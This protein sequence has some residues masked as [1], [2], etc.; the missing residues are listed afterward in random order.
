M[1]E[2]TLVNR[3]KIANGVNGCE[4]IVGRSDQAFYYDIRGGHLRQFKGPY[5][6]RG[7]NSK[8]R[9]KIPEGVIQFNTV[10]KKDKHANSYEVFL[11]GEA[12]RI[13]VANYH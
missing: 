8:N 13:I 12:G 9:R 3:K 2:N 10:C 7:N 5:Y 6:C 1:V 4:A 11:V